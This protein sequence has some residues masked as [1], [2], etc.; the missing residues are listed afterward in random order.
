MLH[1]IRQKGD[2]VTVLKNPDDN[3]PGPAAS[4]AEDIVEYRAYHSA[5]ETATWATCDLREYLNGDFLQKFTRDERSMIVETA[6][7][8]EDNPRRRRAGNNNATNDRV[9]LL[10][11][12]EVRTYFRNDTDRRATV[13]GTP[14]WWWL[15]SSGHIELDAARVEYDG[16]VNT[17][18]FELYSSPVNG[19]R[20]GFGFNVN[21]TS[22]G[23]RPVL[24]LNLGS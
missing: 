2:I 19:F 18:G 9:F 15:R 7:Q 14:Y 24:W 13:N 5:Q 1:E 4:E 10:S 22:G 23:V 12:K 11:T 8:N 20:V 17:F 16:H 3:G 21:T 6:V